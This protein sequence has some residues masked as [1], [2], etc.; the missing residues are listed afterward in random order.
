MAIVE[1]EPLGIELRADVMN[2][3][4]QIFTVL[5]GQR[6]N[7]MYFGIYKA[8]TTIDISGVLSKN[9][10][11][12]GNQVRLTATTDYNVANVSGAATMIFDTRFSCFYFSHIE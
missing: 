2:V 1:H 10:I 12:L 5:D 8:E 9:R 3:P 4:R 7:D 6:E 11:Y